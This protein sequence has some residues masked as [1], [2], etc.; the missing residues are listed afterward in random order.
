MEKDEY[1]QTQQKLLMFGLVVRNMPLN[2][3]INAAEKADAFGPFVNPTLWM[4][5]QEN[6]HRVL[7]LARALRGFQEVLEEEENQHEKV[8]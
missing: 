8:S 4:K 6:L 2:D 5:G 7:K 1:V 3:F